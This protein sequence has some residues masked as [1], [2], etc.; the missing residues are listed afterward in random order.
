VPTQAWRSATTLPREI[1]LTKNERTYELKFKPVSELEKIQ[2]ESKKL[3][4]SAK[5]DPLSLI[6]FNLEESERAFIV[7]IAN[8]MNENV[9]ISFHQGILS[10]DRKNSGITDF[11]DVFPAIHTMDL[12]KVDVKKVSLYLDLSSVEIFINEGERVMT[13]IVFPNTPYN[14]VTLEKENP[15][16]NI[17][18]ISTTLK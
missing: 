16:M 17:S 9:T 14:Y 10:I 1:T 7:T 12:S 2:W 11:S 15:Q 4:G 6:T 3:S 5:L 18:T 8:E 13:E